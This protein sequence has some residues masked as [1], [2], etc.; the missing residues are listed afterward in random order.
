MSTEKDAERGARLVFK[1]LKQFSD[2]KDDEK[3]RVKRAISYAKF[4]RTRR[5][6]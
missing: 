3:E 6:S 5:E 2:R 4:F 1:E